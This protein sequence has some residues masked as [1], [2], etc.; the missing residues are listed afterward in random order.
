MSAQESS[1]VRLCAAILPTSNQCQQFALK[2]RLWCHSHAIAEKRELN[3]FNRQFLA[4]V[5]NMNLLQVAITLSNTIHS[6]RDR[7][8]PPL[9]ATAIFDAAAFRM[10]QLIGELTPVPGSA[11]A[12]PPAATRN[13]N[14]CQEKR[15]HLAPMK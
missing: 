2:N 11:A 6:V 5:G 15:L 14:S 4:A 13:S 9:H 3:E 10:E 8:I 1:K 12:T 7:T